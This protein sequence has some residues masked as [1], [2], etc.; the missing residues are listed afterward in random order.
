MMIIRYS[1][2]NNGYTFYPKNDDNLPFSKMIEFSVTTEYV[3]DSLLYSVAPLTGEGFIISNLWVL[4]LTLEEHQL[5]LKYGLDLLETHLF[6]CHV[7]SQAAKTM[8]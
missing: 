1:G 3:N 6:L 2:G 7:R 4:K 5:H 8:T